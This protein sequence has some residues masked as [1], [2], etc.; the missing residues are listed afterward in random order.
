ML[1]IQTQSGT[2]LTV[3]TQK[4][5]PPDVAPSPHLYL[6]VWVSPH[7]LT[8][9]V[10]HHH[11]PD[12]PILNQ[13]A[14]RL[15]LYGKG[16]VPAHRPVRSEEYCALS[17]LQTGGKRLSSKTG[18][19]GDHN[20]AYL[21]GRVEHCHQ[22]RD[23]RHIQAHCVSSDDA[24]GFQSI[25]HPAHDSTKLRKGQSPALT[26]LRNPVQRRPGAPL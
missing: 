9:P 1:S 2:L 23:H 10:Q 20:G 14:I 11:S 7:I 25:R 22:L 13:S 26:A 19:H 16:I 21:H 17:I 8:Q 12:A 4:I 6:Q 18:K 15:R 3:V 5:I 24:L